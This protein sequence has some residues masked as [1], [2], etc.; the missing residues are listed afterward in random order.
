[1]CA[2]GAL[3]FYLSIARKNFLLRKY[4][5]GGIFSQ[6]SRSEST[7]VIRHNAYSRHTFCLPGPPAQCS[8]SSHGLRHLVQVPGVGQLQ[9][10]A[11][12]RDTSGSCRKA[13][14]RR[15]LSVP[16]SLLACVRYLPLPLY[17]LLTRA[18]ILRGIR[19]PTY[20]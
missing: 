8:V 16:R 12:A 13:S 19:S 14:I 10:A 11:C 18:Q 4:A 9:L 15:T 7:T 3:V 1:M 6:P 20:R 17:I 5:S 2:A